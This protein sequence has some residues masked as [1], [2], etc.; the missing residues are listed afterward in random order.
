M[1]NKKWATQIWEKLDKKLS[2]TAVS[3]YDKIPYT[4]QNGIHDNRGEK[5]ICWWTNGFWP[6]L[7]ILMYAG[8]KKEQYLKTARHCMDLLDRAL[9][10]YS[11]L[12]HDVGFM[13]NISSGT[14]YQI[15]GDKTQ[16]NR[17]LIAANHLMGRYNSN[18]EYIVA[19][20]GENNKGRAIIDCMMNIPL[21][22]R[23]SIELNDDRFA[24]VARNHANKTMKYHV[25]PDGGC[26]HINE[27]NPLTGAFMGD[28]RGQGYAS[29][30]SWTRGQAWGIY[31]FALS[32]RY[33]KDKEYLATA[34]KIAN[35]FIANVQRTDWIASCDFMQPLEPFVIDTTAN[36]IAACGMLEIADFVGDNEK[37]LYYDAAVKLLMAAEEKYCDWSD[38]EDS[39]L[40]MGTEAYHFNKRH[41][42]IIYGDYFFAEGIYR[43]MGY[44]SSILW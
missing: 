3:S 2:R 27:Y 38:E 11:G 24:M 29:Q 33:T 14:D 4:T 13:W 20:N 23:V 39:I 16:R 10:D 40:Q 18:G 35:Y 31:G 37:S 6:A 8:T 9:M 42:P 41:I 5:E 25:R 15:T 28:D 1:S 32:Y 19:W 43:L 17:F 34:K 36:V 7:M 12:H 30:S 22:Y 44:D 26:N 21:L